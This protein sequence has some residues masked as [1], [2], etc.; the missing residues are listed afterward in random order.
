MVRPPMIDVMALTPHPGVRI[1]ATLT[2]E[3]DRD[4]NHD[5]QWSRSSSRNGSYSNIADADAMTYTPTAND[6]GY[7]LRAAVSYR[8]GEGTGKS[9]MATSMH[10]V[11]VI[12]VAE[13]R[14]SVPGSGLDHETP[15]T[16]QHDCHA[17]GDRE[18]GG[19]CERGCRSQS[20]RRQRRH[21][22]P[23][24]DWR[25]NMA[26]FKIDPATGQITVAADTIINFEGRREQPGGHATRL[27]Y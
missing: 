10:P 20:C 25:G 22:D 1:T 9:A 5:W 15:I 2:D 16:G 11:Q 23:H 12:Q 24:A 14:A 4:R 18:C 13:C 19:G 27:R 7:F 26:S 6:V 21:P 17:D 8:D 3:D